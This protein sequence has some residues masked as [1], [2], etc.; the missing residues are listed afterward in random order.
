[1]VIIPVNPDTD[2]IELSASIEGMNLTLQNIMEAIEEGEISSM[3]VKV[4]LTMV[5]HTKASKTF[6]ERL[7]KEYKSL[8]LNTTINYQA[9]P[10]KNKHKTGSFVVEK[11]DTRIGQSYLRLVEEIE[12]LN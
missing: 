1:M 4:L 2:D 9:A 8:V 5:D 10:I 6:E 3:E 12:R 7:R 11:K